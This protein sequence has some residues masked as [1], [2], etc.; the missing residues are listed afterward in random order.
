MIESVDDIVVV[1][2]FDAKFFDFIHG[3]LLWGNF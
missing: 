1:F 3:V 2:R